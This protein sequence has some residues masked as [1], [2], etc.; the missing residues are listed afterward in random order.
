MQV[1][2]FGDFLQ[3]GPIDNTNERARVKGFARRWYS[4]ED[5]RSRV[6]RG[7]SSGSNSS[8]M[9][10]TDVGRTKVTFRRSS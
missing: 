3:L 7:A 4:T 6:G 9:L 5:G 2:L 8:S 10:P 1:V